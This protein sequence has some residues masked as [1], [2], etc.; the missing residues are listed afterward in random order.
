MFVWNKTGAVA[1]S[2][3]LVFALA[4]FGGIATVGSANAQSGTCACQVSPGATGVLE[5]VVGKVFVRQAGGSTAAQS[6]IQLGAGD[7]VMVG[8]RSSSTVSFGGGCSVSLSANTT[9]QALPQGNQLC[10]AVNENA[11]GAVQDASA[12]TGASSGIPTAGIVAIGGGI[13]LGAVLLSTSDEG[14]SN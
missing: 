6:G 2:S 12:A 10:V 13:A 3:A 8:P 7:S 14:V 11:A 9:L 1:R 5:N 4:A